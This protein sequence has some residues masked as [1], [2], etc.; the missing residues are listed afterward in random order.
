MPS[1]NRVQLIGNL[2]FEPE[3][4]YTTGGVPVCGLRMAINR[5]YKNSR[6]EMAEDVVYVDIEAWDKLAE[7]CQKYLHKGSPLFVDG[8]LK[9][10]EWEDRDTGKKR[11]KLK[12]QAIEVQFLDSRQSSD[13]PPSRSRY[14]DDDAPPARQPA[15]RPL[16]NSDPPAPD[17]G[18]AQLPGNVREVDGDDGPDNMDSVPF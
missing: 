5:K 17:T 13:Q 6:G 7:N 15:P 12:I 3:L 11:S 18:P 8:R 10:D 2:T 9:T 4:R 1:Y 14:T 16:R